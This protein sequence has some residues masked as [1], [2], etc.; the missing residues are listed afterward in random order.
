MAGTVITET[1]RLIIREIDIGDARALFELYKDSEVMKYFDNRPNSVEQEKRIIQKHIE[2]FYKRLGFGFWALVL[3]DTGQV[4]GQ[5]GLLPQM[6]DD[7]DETE[8]AYALLGEFR[9]KGYATEAAK[10]VRDYGF[11]VRNF[12]RLISIIQPANTQS[13]NVALRTGLT[14]EKTTIFE[15]KPAEIY[16]IQKSN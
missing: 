2:D 1:Q 5:S 14:L 6:V 8:I 7:K 15:D 13:K 16:S 3:K 11:Y 4:I 10:S 12:D 9:K